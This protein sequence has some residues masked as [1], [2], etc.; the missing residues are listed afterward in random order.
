MEEKKRILFIRRTPKNKYSGIAN[1]CRA[2]YAMFS[3]D[4]ELQP[5]DIV[6][7]P[8]RHSALFH[9]YYR[10]KPLYQAIRQADIVHVNG[11]T[12]LGA[13]QALLMAK[14]MGKKT[15]Y[16]AHWHPFENLSHPT[17]GKLFFNL[18]VKPAIKCCADVVTTINN[19]DTRFFQTFHRHV[20]QIPHWYAPLSDGGDSRKRSNM[21]LFV[22]RL[23]DPV[24]GVDYLQRL[25]E[26]RYDIHL[27]GNGP[28]PSR[29][30][31]TQHCNIPADELAHLYREASVLVIPSKYEAFSYAALE[32]LACGTPVLMSDRVRI[33]DYLDGVAGFRIF[34]YGDYDGFVKAIDKTITLPVDSQRVT[35]IFSQTA[36]RERY[37]NEVYL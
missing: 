29:T 4:S 2:L 19:E 27:V 22:G 33:A 8:A 28:K 1:Y 9:F 18:F 35:E 25:P 34:H 6:D 32:A 13:A 36:I 17:G 15:V 26:G 30:D 10:L 20:V 3:G 16:T 37:K 14:W 12:E 11:Y 24:K 23:S 7:Y 5:L 31:M 21:V